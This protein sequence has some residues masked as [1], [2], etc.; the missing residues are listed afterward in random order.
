[1]IAARELRQQAGDTRIG[2]R[3][4]RT[5]HPVVRATTGDPERGSVTV[6]MSA[7]ISAILMVT[8]SGLILASAVLASHRARTAG[9][10]AALAASGVLIRGGP[11]AM[12]CVAARRVAAAN[13][14][15]VQRCT[16]AGMEASLSVSVPSGLQEM[17][18]ATARSRAGPSQS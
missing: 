1:V 11:S 6:I 7:V 3:P 12:A 16:T 9:D 5:R 15:E 14:A 13:Q 18:I 2:S 17:R 4:F 8:V 10:L